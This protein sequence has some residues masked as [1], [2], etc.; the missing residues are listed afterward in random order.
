ML[1]QNRNV[2]VPPELARMTQC[3]EQLQSG[4]ASLPAGLIHSR[5]SVRQWFWNHV[6]PGVDDPIR[7]PGRD[8]TKTTILHGHSR[9]LAAV[10]QDVLESIEDLTN[11][12]ISPA[13][14]GVRRRAQAGV[15]DPSPSPNVI[16]QANPNRHREVTPFR[17]PNDQSSTF[18]EPDINAGRGQTSGATT[19]ER[20]PPIDKHRKVKNQTI[21][22]QALLLN[23]EALGR[24]KV[25][26]EDD[27]TPR[28]SD[29]NQQTFEETYDRGR[30]PGGIRQPSTVAESKQQETRPLA[31]GVPQHL[32]SGFYPTPTYHPVPFHGAMNLNQHSW[33][34]QG[35]QHNP[36]VTPS[37]M[38]FGM[39]WQ[40]TYHQPPPAFG[41]VPLATYV[42]PPMPYASAYARPPAT[43]RLARM[44]NRATPSPGPETAIF[45]PQSAATA[46]ISEWQNRYGSQATVMPDLPVLPYRVG[47]DDMYRI[48]GGAASSRYQDLSRASPLTLE[49]VT[50]E[51]NMPFAENAKLMKPPQWGVLKIGN[52]SH[53][54]L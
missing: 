40:P 47:S 14:E 26:E 18:V 52:V 8:S 49:M 29:K 2:P 4:T 5:E 38:G 33:G 50:A 15:A 34:V 25:R 41:Q 45:R 6:F 10:R 20:S 16:A 35:V 9:T 37:S 13:G 23:Q 22:N 44:F 53:K 11:F 36:Y 46:P 43:G 42:P 30:I 12:I 1:T 51:E 39:Q 24:F 31:Y 7:L 21:V 48:P 54:F 17:A 32:A 19:S 3:V 27:E 28:P